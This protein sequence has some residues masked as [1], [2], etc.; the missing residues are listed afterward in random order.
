MT[1]PL[2]I[3]ALELLCVSLWEHRSLF[4]VLGH[5]ADAR[6][7]ASMYT[8]GISACARPL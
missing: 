1:F 3:D 2:Q 6:L 7:D 5:D 8:L 4:K